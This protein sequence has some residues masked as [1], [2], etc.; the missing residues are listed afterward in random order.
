MSDVCLKKKHTIDPWPEFVWG[1]FTQWLEI[2]MESK[3]GGLGDDFSFSI[4][5]FLGSTCKCSGAVLNYCTCFERHLGLM[6][7]V[8]YPLYQNPF[9]QWHPLG[10][11][12][13]CSKSVWPKFHQLWNFT[14][15]ISSL[16]LSMNTT[17]LCSWRDFPESRSEL[18]GPRVGGRWTTTCQHDRYA[19]T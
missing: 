4:G 2:N 17:Q 11:H 1:T 5:W 14:Q 18:G 12:L 3:N 13:W 7:L 10:C 16:F 9:N 15:Q 8:T 19:D 6:R